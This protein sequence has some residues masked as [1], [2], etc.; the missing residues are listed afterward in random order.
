MRTEVEE[1]A[2]VVAEA[3][4]WLHTPWQHMAAIKGECCD[5]AMLLVRSFVDAGVLEPFDPRPY[6]RAWF[7]HHEEERFLGWVVDKFNAVEVPVDQAQPGDVLM[8]KLGR[9]YAHGAIL[10]A[11]KLV[12]HAFSENRKVIYTETF[13]P[14]LA[15]KKPRAFDI[16]A[17]RRG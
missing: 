12:I 10:V 7:L 17:H 4:S 9:C 16:W 8:Y 11:P 13:D 2:A 15:T 3:R 6:P 1:R 14:R 5:C